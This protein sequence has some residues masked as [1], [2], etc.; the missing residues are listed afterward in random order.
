MGVVTGEPRSAS[1][2][3]A[4]EVECYRLDKE[5]FQRHFANIKFYSITHE[6]ERYQHEWMR[7]RCQPG[8]TV[9]EAH[10]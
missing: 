2:I 7:S 4:T 6:S 3:A 9:I 8:T 1:V 10:F 5:A